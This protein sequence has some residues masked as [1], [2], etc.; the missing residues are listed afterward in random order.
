MTRHIVFSLAVRV[1]AR[2]VPRTWS[3]TCLVNANYCQKEASNQESD[4]QIFM[5]QN[6]V[7]LHYT[8]DHMLWPPSLSS[9]STHSCFCLIGLALVIWLGSNTSFLHQILIGPTYFSIAVVCITL[10]LLALNLVWVQ[11][12]TCAGWPLIMG[13]PW[14]HYSVMKADKSDLVK[15]L[16]LK[17]HKASKKVVCD[18][19]SMQKTFCFLLLTV[20]MC[21]T[22][23]YTRLRDAQCPAN[24]FNSTSVARDCDWGDEGWDNLCM[25]GK[26]GWVLIDFWFDFYG[27]N[28]NSKKI[29]HPAL[30]K[31]KCS[32]KYP[33]NREL[34]E[35]PLPQFLCFKRQAVIKGINRIWEKE[36]MVHSL[37]GLV[38]KKKVLI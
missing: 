25:F 35:V 1:W 26:T 10:W 16:Q 37:L 14:N 11:S 31:F 28:N 32:G 6:F 30:A 36:I 18:W 2:A 13:D 9:F 23:S 27:E 24:F 34:Q 20:L 12:V 15:V 19:E 33:T 8:S 22:P 7:S 4:L 3:P 38:W 29:T 21:K 5:K 17:T